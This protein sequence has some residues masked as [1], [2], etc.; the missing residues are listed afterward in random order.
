MTYLL[1]KTPCSIAIT[2][3]AKTNHLAG[4]IQTRKTGFEKLSP[5]Y[6]VM[7]TLFIGFGV[8][9]FTSDRLR[10]Q[11][12]DRNV[13]YCCW[14]TFQRERSSPYILILSSRPC[15]RRW[16]SCEPTKIKIKA[17]SH[18]L[19]TKPKSHQDKVPKDIIGSF[20]QAFLSICIYNA[21]QASPDLRYAWLSQA[22]G[23]PFL[24]NSSRQYTTV[25][26][27]MHN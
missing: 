1:P 26:Y 17:M 23:G 25:H 24:A 5:L 27:S 22:R 19:P 18:S 10:M 3:C 8:F 11:R 20:M 4:F 6:I 16:L 13:C 14:I 15:Q 9:I 7:E 21:V 12:H 2:K